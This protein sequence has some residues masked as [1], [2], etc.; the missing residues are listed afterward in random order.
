[1]DEAQADAIGTKNVVGLV[2]DTTVLT[3]VA[4]GVQASGFFEA[5]TVEWDAVTGDSG[6]LTAGEKYFLD[7]D[8]A[9]L[10]TLN[11]STTEGDY[12]AAIGIALSAT[13]FRIAINQ[14]VK[15]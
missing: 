14:T 5:T 8:T 11:A 9:G 2:V 12:I 10:L 3:G 6:G 4:A 7:P 15:L 13:E 1:V